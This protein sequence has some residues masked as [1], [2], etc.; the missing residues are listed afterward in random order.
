MKI[1]TWREKN[2]IKFIL[3]KDFHC[4]FRAERILTGIK[5]RSFRRFYKNRENQI[6]FLSD[7]K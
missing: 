1:F 6:K 3:K 4:E 7:L 5:R 2:I